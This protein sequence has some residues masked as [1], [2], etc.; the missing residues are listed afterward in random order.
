MLE[1]NKPHSA[2]KPDILVNS[3]ALNLALNSLKRGSV[4]QQEIAAELESTAVTLD[5]WKDQIMNNLKEFA[6]NLTKERPNKFLGIPFHYLIEDP[7]DP[8]FVKPKPDLK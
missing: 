6:K 2:V 1:S 5:V 8:D 4:S 7:S 3:G